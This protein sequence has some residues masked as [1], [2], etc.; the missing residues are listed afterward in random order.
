MVGQP[1]GEK[2][3]GGAVGAADDGDRGGLGEGEPERLRGQQG[4]EDAE[5]RRRAEQKVCG[6]ASSGL[7]SVIAPRPRKISG[8]NT[9]VARPVNM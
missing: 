6:L 3:R 8:G 7:K 4:A 1:R 2:D 9:P 5:L